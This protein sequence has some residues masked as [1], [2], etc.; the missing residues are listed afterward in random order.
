MN[1]VGK[2]ALYIFIATFFLVG[3]FH[4]VLL[5]RLFKQLV[6]EKSKGKIEL[7]IN[8][9]H[10]GLHYGTIS[11]DK[12]SVIFEDLYLDRSKS[13]KIEKIIFDEV[14]IEGLDIIS[15]IIKKDIIADR[16]FVDKPGFWLT[17]NGRVSKSDVQPKGFAKALKLNGNQFSDF[18]VSIG[19]I[20]IHY[21]SI[22]LSQ[23]TVA[24]FDPGLVDFSIN[25]K[26]FSTLHDTTNNNFTFYSDE[27]RFEMRN[28][29]KLLKTGYQMDVDSL[30]FSSLNRD[31]VLEGVSFFPSDK[32]DNRNSIGF[33]TQRIAL[34]NIGIEDLAKLNDLHLRSVVLSQGMFVTYLNNS[35]RANDTTQNGSVDKLKE[36]L[37]SIV[38]DTIL[39]DRFSYY[40]IVNNNDTLVSASDI[41]FEAS[42]VEIDS[43][44][45]AD[46]VKQVGFE[47]VSINT[48]S[49]VF[50]NR[51]SN[52]TVNY[53]QLTYSNDERQLGVK[54][55]K[56]IDS[57][58]KGSKPTID[59]NVPE[60]RL[61]GLSIHKLQKNQKQ[62]ISLYL[63]EPNGNITIPDSVTSKD[64]VNKPFVLP[65]DIFFYE[66][67]VENG[68]FNIIKKNRHKMDIAGLNFSVDGL[69]IP[70]KGNDSLYFEIVDIS[71]DEINVFFE[72]KNAT[73]R[74]GS[75]SYQ[76]SNALS[77][78]DVKLQQ[79]SEAGENRVE[80]QTL[81][82]SG[83]NEGLLVSSHELCFDTLLLSKLKVDSEMII[84]KDEGGKS[85]RNFGELVS[86]VQLSI[87]R[88][89]IED[90]SVN[91]S[92]VLNGT[93]LK[94]NAGFNTSVG[95]IDVDR[96]DTL[97]TVLQDVSWKIDVDNLVANS[98]NHKLR[99]SS[100]SADSYRLEFLAEQ[101]FISPDEDFNFDSA[102]F[103][104]R[105]FSLPVFDV[106]GLN[107]NL[108]VWN[109][110][111]DCSA[112]HID[113]P[114]IDMTIKG[115]R[116]VALATQKDKL[117]DLKQI[118]LFRYDTVE[119]AGLNLNIERKG[120][121]RDEVV[122]INELDFSHYRTD[123]RG[124]S[125]L[126]DNL[127]FNMNGFN[128]YNRLTSNSFAIEQSYINS[129]KNRLY[130]K[131]ASSFTLN[132]DGSIVTDKKSMG[133]SLDTLELSGI[134][135]QQT[136]P[137]RISARKLEIDDIDLNL[138]VDKANNNSTQELNVNPDIMK[139][140]SNVIS[141]LQLDT[142]IVD[143]VSFRVNTLNGEVN[144]SF[145]LDSL[146]ILIEKIKLDTTL[147]NMARPTI[148]DQITIDLKGNTRIS[149]DSLYEIHSG[150]LHYNFPN[151]KIVVDSFYVT[152]LYEDSE[153][154]SRYGYQTDRI[155]LFVPR[156]EI[157]KIDLNEL[158]T[159]NHLQ[160]SHV[161]LYQS[162]GEIYRDKHYPFKPGIFK[163]LPR[164]QIMSIKRMF[165]IDTIRIIDSYLKYK[166]LSEKADEPGE[167]HL[168]NVNVSAYNLTNYL[169]DD[170]ERDLIIK[171]SGNIMGQA[172]MVM[173]LHFP[174]HEGGQAFTLRGKTDNI[175][176]S[177]LNPLTT[178]LLGIGII[179]GTGSIDVNYVEGFD[180]TALGSLIFKYKKLRLLPYSRNKEK[181]RS[182]ALSPLLSFMINDL[183]VKSNN[184][185][186]ARKPRVGQVYFE[187]DTRKGVINFI[188]KGVLSGITSTMGFNNK[189]QRKVKKVER[190]N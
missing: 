160:I 54:G 46:I 139:R 26:G 36:M 92:V 129:K 59:V 151:Q 179:K 83:F 188:W 10:F 30:V 104:I 58:V 31:I 173:N 157:D 86:P 65:F 137:T 153:F 109:D 98:F 122:A 34:N 176:L 74:V 28:L 24:D 164:E 51:L 171:F 12:P 91:G 128:F 39:I 183:V 1:K 123:G 162:E 148:I 93:T 19:D 50:K 156:I 9:F 106:S 87:S 184:P 81:S 6:Y 78:N 144:N 76:S 89:L 77:L 150:K 52:V 8:S 107:Y 174:L 99:I 133:F 152:P 94:L 37:S 41:N 102:K 170:E 117:I 121:D 73:I 79:S 165:T 124:D 55:V 90:G 161:N 113:K 155:D 136:L 120:V 42:D 17:E 75:M 112:I 44:M 16:V 67:N 163:L 168:D 154:F 105:S 118:P 127:R 96:G 116:D 187:R 56:L 186:F 80:I 32:R 68:N 47:D 101:I 189:E 180:S 178:N 72:K 5:S 82:L 126:I 21:G 166:E 20:V 147:A 97:K 38:I 18:I 23:N 100:L 141:L 71:S 45:Y 53:D 103:H 22:N 185:K 159:K 84:D 175:N 190:R 25:L 14:S 85:N 69:Q 33:T 4:D 43:S 49:F 62:N 181:L 130:I 149:K 7:T 131:G 66:L 119:I 132:K 57:S 142:A 27:F 140:F 60:I 61:K 125:N 70:E 169:K 64:S 145:N 3:I 108:L 29:H 13:V 63:I 48:G 40:N 138:V 110:S 15:L 177:I 95:T 135:V 11:F 182:G 172:G 143:D 167:V 88:I 114:V 134:M 158:V 35:G 115:D 2:I 146:G 111:L